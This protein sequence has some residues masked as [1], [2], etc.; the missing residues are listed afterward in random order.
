MLFPRETFSALGERE[1]RNRESLIQLVGELR[2]EGHTLTAIADRLGFSREHVRNLEKEFLSSKAEI[3]ETASARLEGIGQDWIKPEHFVLSIL[4]SGLQRSIPLIVWHQKISIFSNSSGVWYRRGE[5]AWVSALMKKLPLTLQEAESLI[6]DLYVPGILE[7]AKDL[8]RYEI[9]ADLGLVRNSAKVR[10]EIFLRLLTNGTSLSE[11][12]LSESLK[13]SIRNIRAHVD[14]DKR[15]VRNVA[16]DEIALSE[17][18]LPGFAI[19]DARSALRFVLEKQGPQKRIDLIRKA[20]ALYPRTLGRYAQLLEDPEFGL[21][22]SGLIGLTSEGALRAPDEEP[23]RH[24]SINEHS[25]EVISLTV[26]ITRDV[27]R[28]AG[29]PVHKRLG[30]LVG[31]RY[32]GESRAFRSVNLANTVTIKRFPGN[33]SLSSIRKIILLLGVHDG[34]TVEFAFNLPES[35]FA[36][37]GTCECHWLVEAGPS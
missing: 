30:W 36:V 25:G 28:G 12:S 9:L 21:T 29:V 15:F 1:V 3:L 4:G 6:G 24:R 27:L 26:K 8:G 20:A 18:H 14:R 22:G 13:V 17:W 31:L 34:C 16:T 33:V 2:L 11:T 37:R 32:V 10:D 7:A 23:S 19:K 35:I 5:P